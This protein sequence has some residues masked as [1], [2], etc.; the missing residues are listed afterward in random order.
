ML[1]CGVLAMNPQLGRNTVPFVMLL[2]KTGVWLHKSDILRASPDGII[3]RAATHNYNHQVIELTDF[4]EGMA[5]K[6]EVLEVKCPLSARIMT[7]SEAIESV[8]DFCLEYQTFEDRQ[9][10]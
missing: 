9:F 2:W 6:P 3:R 7:I 1:F 8:K 5:V 10:Y 4:L